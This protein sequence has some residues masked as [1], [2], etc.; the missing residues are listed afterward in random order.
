MCLRFACFL[1]LLS[2]VLVSAASGQEA[3]PPADHASMDNTL[4][5]KFKAVPGT[6][7]LFSVYE[8]RVADFEAFL[9]AGTYKERPEMLKPHFE[10]TPEDPVVLVNLQD[11]IAFCNWLTQKEQAEGK[12]KTNQG[13]RLPTGKE[14]NAAA[15]LES[16]KPSRDMS[17]TAK[18]EESLSFV[19]GPQWPPPAGAG[20]FQS[21]EIPGYKDDYPFTSPVGKFKPTAT[22]LYDVA[23]NVWEWTMDMRLSANAEGGALR[24]GSW[25]YF[26]RECLTSA[27]IYRV[28]V[29][30]RA[31]TVGFRCVFEDKKRTADMLAAESVAELNA[32]KKRQE[33][34]TQKGNVDKEA[35]DKLLKSNAEAEEV[36]ALD[37][38]TLSPATP[39]KPFTQPLRLEFTPLAGTKV[40]FGRTE[41]MLSAWQAYAKATGFRG[42]IQPVFTSS[43]QH[44]VVGVSWDEAMAFCEWLTYQDH[45]THLLPANARYRL[46]KDTEWSM[47]AGLANETGADPAAKH[48]ANKTRFP[49]G[50]G[51]AA[52]PPPSL[53]A[54][55]D[56]PNVP[57]YRDNFAKTAPVGSMI[58][59]KE[60]IHDLGG[61]VSEWCEDAWPDAPGERVIR[62]G[63]WIS[64]AKEALLSSARQHQAKTFSRSDLGFRIVVDFGS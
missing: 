24:G 11:S 13:Y 15:G 35:V 48:L 25:A 57:G 42:A 37:P 22:G 62:G 27:Y 58:P 50:D 14:W 43:P 28:P 23:G 49:W 34:M 3:V 31:P 47:A 38:K 20:N 12:I 61:N 44:P 5:M 26:R 10:Q 8:T 46:P 41:I 52:W 17:T 54:N 21:S 4:G 56:A 33:E 60:G 18:V 1:C 7:I 6:T 63:S 64:S 16:S 36:A 59:T 29:T 45:S 40:L 19:W 39:D 51:A 53:S 30:L 2:C 55:I 32:L 9:K